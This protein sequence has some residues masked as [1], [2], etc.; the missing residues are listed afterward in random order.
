MASP[1]GYSRTQIVLHWVIALLILL[2]FL[3]RDNIETVWEAVQKG[4]MEG[5][6]F[7][8]HALVG[9]ITLLL[10]IW[11]LALRRRRGAPDLPPGGSALQDFVA[12]WTH[13]ILY[14]LLFLIPL[15]GM[16]AWGG[17]V[18]AAASIHGPMFFLAL[19]LIVL[20]IAGAIYHQYVLKDGLIRRMMKSE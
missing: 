3:F 7:H 11:R 19:L 9:T 16:A 17:G 1:T 13:R 4:E 8:P 15:S 5:G 12:I 18:V 2:Q 14:V 20:H 10:V 6:G